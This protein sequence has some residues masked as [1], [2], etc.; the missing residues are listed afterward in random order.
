M[1]GVVIRFSLKHRLLIVFLCVVVL[2][3]G[4]Y[5][6]TTMPLDVLPDLDRPRVVVLTEAPGLAPEA[7]EVQVTQQIEPIL[8]GL[9]GGQAIRSE[10]SPSLSVIRA[11]FD[12][13]TSSRD[14]RQ[15]LR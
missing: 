12:W 10:S 2:L 9:P 11:E 4:G 3:Y 14:A 15:S 6:S 8:L 5:L 1:V 7:V 13:S